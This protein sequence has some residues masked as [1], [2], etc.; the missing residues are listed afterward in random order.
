MLG[1]V[2]GVG[3]FV[4][5][6]GLT[7]TAGNQISQRFTELAATEVYVQDVGNTS[8]DF[9]ASSF[10]SDADDKAA[11]LDGV[12][13][14]GVWWPLANDVLETVAAGPGADSAARSAIS[15]FAASPGL[16]GAIRPEVQE[17]RLYDDFHET[18]GQ[19][20]AVL[21]K[22]AASA[23]GIGSLAQRPAIM[24][25]SMAFTVIGVV[26][27]VER[28]P[29]LL[30]AVL[31]PRTTA[32]QLWGQAE[33]DRGAKMLVDA[34]PG[35][36]PIVATQIAIALRPD[37][38]DAFKVTPPPNPRDLRE[39]VA[40]DLSGLFFV[41]AGICLV[42]GAIGIA[43]T[44]LVAVLERVPEIG[45]RRAV[46]ARPRHIAAQFLTEAGLLGTIGGCVGASIGIIAVVVIAAVNQWTPVMDPALLLPSPL[47]GTV[48]GIVS[49]VYPALRAARIEPMDALRVG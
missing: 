13:S 31:L 20:V 3:V 14:A 36:A 19:R 24:I 22:G 32:E 15:V 30:N 49:G 42:V 2:L 39:A 47:L 33:P 16:L 48:V 8:Y 28:E 6:L 12:R 40:A 29:G 34:D 35:A 17:G 5:V 45:L 9:P 25:S 38:P 18:A 11:R 27:D 23:L 10:P 4:G 37:K 7:A 44:T 1:T 21:G 43:N 26:S 46:G 41:L